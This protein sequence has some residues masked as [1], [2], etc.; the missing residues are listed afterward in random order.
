MNT[1]DYAGGADA[2]AVW[3]DALAGVAALRPAEVILLHAYDDSRPEV[4]DTLG[5]VEALAEHFPFATVTL[6]DTA[7]VALDC[8]I[9][10]GLPAA[11]RTLQGVDFGLSS[12]Y[13]TALM[14][15]FLGVPAYLMGANAYFG[16]KA[17]LFDL[18]PL[19]EFLQD[20]SRFALDITDHLATRRSWIARLD[21]MKFEG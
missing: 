18:P 13:H 9:G 6:I 3:R 20:P 16:Q 7:R 14:M 5:T 8:E 12:S 4:R 2:L 15:T 19:E 21:A 10:A 17:K 11:L 1:S